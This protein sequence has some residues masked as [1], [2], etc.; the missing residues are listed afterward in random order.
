MNRRRTFTHTI[1]LPLL[2]LSI[3][4]VAFSQVSDWR[5]IAIPP[6]PAFNPQEPKRIQL[7]NGMV[8]FLQPDHEL[9]FISGTMRI[10]GGS[11][12]EPAGKVGLVSLYGRS[13][14]TGGTK[15]QTGDA[16]DD[17]LEAR[18]ARVETFGGL[19][20]A[21]VSWDCLKSDFEDVFKVVL[22]LL[23]N[24]EFREDKIAL[25]KRQMDTAIARRND[26]PSSIANREAAMLGYGKDSPYART[27]EYATV[28]AVTRSDLVKWHE[29][30][31]HPNNIILGVS[32]D[33]D[34]D[35]VEARLKAAFDSWERGPDLSQAEAAIEPAKP[36]IYFVP[37]DDVNQSEI[38]MVEL[39]TRRDNP[40]YYAI[41]V[42]NEIF[43]GSFASRLVED[44]RSKRGLAYEVG[45]GIGTGFDHPGLVRV[46][47]G[48]K[49]GTTLAAIQALE[50]DIAGLKKNPPT[51]EELRKAKDDI[52]N[53][54]IFAFDSKQKVLGERMNYE[55]Y[56]YPANFLERY[57]TGIEK[58]TKADVERV[59]EKYI[60][61]DQLAVLV[62]GKASDFDKPL[63]TLGEVKTLDVTIPPL[64]A[65]QAAES[66]TSNPEGKALMA[67]IVEALGGPDKV[68]SVKSVR[69]EAN[70]TFTT[71]Q[72]D[73][74]ISGAEIIVYPDHVWQRIN[75]L[76]GEM[77]MVASPSVAF[78]ATAMESHE[79]PASQKQDMLNEVKRDL[80]Y[81][82]QH[83]DDPQFAFTAAGSE[84][85]GGVEA[86]ILDVNADGTSVRWFVDPATGHVLRA[87]WQ[88]ANPEGPAEMIADYSDWRTAG[89]VSV[90]FKETQTRNGEAALA[91]QM[92]K[93]E[94]NPALNMKIFERPAAKGAGNAEP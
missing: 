28:A 42:L 72:G 18:A 15:T 65:G 25:A 37:K 20:D 82:A 36:G 73:V 23:R 9:P 13:W 8:I 16:L 31:V 30:Y 44:I 63:A 77:S 43:G 76:N 90:P 21:S 52:L 68:K 74:T 67:K 70:L 26:D 89:G 69:D 66:V 1:F 57:R 40:D 14:R 39:G 58:V 12:D 64:N 48:T 53:S 88:A 86:V 29:A 80:I 62:V 4:P 54:F 11:R 41:E 56:G 45:G 81:V 51:R 87:R 6:L 35:A 46:G 55:F 93:L 5:Q 71:P 83:A 32:G 27:P 79:L 91:E 75:T 7:A 38:Q 3:A 59:A 10:R 17:Y 22:D 33:F 2:L 92:Q 61:Q 47:M 24:P 60:H 84:K 50:I 78:M 94:I 85:I 49:S 19:D 34:P